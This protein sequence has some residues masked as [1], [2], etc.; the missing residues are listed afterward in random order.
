MIEG[1]RIGMH[2]GV[3]YTFLGDAMVDFGKF[4]MVIYTLLL[5]YISTKIVSRHKLSSFSFSKFLLFILAVRMP[6]LGVFAYVYYGIGTSIVILTTLALAY[7]L[8]K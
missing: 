1:G 8:R 2:L 7:Y 6:L 4:G 3:F 5:S